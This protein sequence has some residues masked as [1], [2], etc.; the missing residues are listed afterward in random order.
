MI[1]K[2]RKKFFIL[3]GKYYEEFGYPR[4]CGWIDS[5]L[6]LEPQDWTQEGISRQL[7]EIFYDSDQ[8]TSLA[9]VN[10]AL[11]ILEK[12]GT[13]I[14]SGSRKLGYKYRAAPSSTILTSMFNQFITT[15]EKVIRELMGLK[16]EREFED[17]QKLQEIVEFEINGIELFNQLLKNIVDSIETEE[18]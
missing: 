7:S 12:Y 18:S 2:T 16:G 17:D 10:R 15:N 9:S 3:M 4:L 13:I 8:P 5:L 14:K 11:K 6:M 1:S